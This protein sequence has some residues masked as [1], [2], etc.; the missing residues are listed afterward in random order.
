MGSEL[1]RYEYLTDA[2]SQHV[3][4]I[5]GILDPDIIHRLGTASASRLFH[6]YGEDQ[7]WEDKEKEMRTATERRDVKAI[8]Y[9]G[10]RADF[11]KVLQNTIMGVS[12]ICIGL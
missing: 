3:T 6:R 9:F 2:D 5:F 11:Q 8:G 7:D 1:C 10:W 12:T 4:Q